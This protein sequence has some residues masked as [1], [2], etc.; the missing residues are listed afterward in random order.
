MARPRVRHCDDCR[1]MHSY[2]PHM[3]KQRICKCEIADRYINGQEI[4]N[5]PQWCP[6]G[7]RVKQS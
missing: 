7:R 5:S 4:R 3:S 2:M 6:L 1:G